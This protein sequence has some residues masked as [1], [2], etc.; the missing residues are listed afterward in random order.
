MASIR[1]ARRDDIPRICDITKSAFGPYALAKLLEDRFGIVDGKPW[2]EH[3]AASVADACAEDPSRFIVAEEDGKVV[4]YASFHCVGDRGDV[5][6]NAVD[7][8][9]QGRGIGSALHRFGLEMLRDRGVKLLTVTTM[10]H[11]APARRIYEKHG[12]HEHHRTV[13]YARRTETGVQ[14]ETIDL[15]DTETAKRLEEQGFD[16]VAVFIHYRMTPA[17]A[18]PRR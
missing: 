1:P 2:H 4:G 18:E 16:R 3:K 10:E 13:K 7:P 14:L 12:F 17:N 11:D 8:A 9:Y 5:G 6:N 15:S